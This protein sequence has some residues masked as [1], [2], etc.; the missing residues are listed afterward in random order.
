MSFKDTLPKF[1]SEWK[2][3]KMDGWFMLDSASFGAFGPI[4]RGVCSLLVSGRIC[5]DKTL[6][7]DCHLY[8][9]CF[10]MK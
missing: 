9:F 4:F 7:R 3:L 2:P 10:L 1:I 8:H 5:S 6:V